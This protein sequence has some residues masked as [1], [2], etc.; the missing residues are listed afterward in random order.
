M[1]ATAQGK[2]FGA[3][4]FSLSGKGHAKEM[5]FLSGIFMVISFWSYW[6]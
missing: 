6:F 5:N 4:E 2:D 1:N 3:I